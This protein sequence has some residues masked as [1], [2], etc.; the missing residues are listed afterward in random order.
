MGYLSSGGYEYDE[1]QLSKETIESLWADFGDVCIDDNECIDTS[2]CGWQRG[3][4]REEI[5][6]WFDAQYA[7]WGGIHV[8]MGESLQ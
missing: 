1:P 3:T 4:W 7:I 5:W 2:F 6:H 8:L